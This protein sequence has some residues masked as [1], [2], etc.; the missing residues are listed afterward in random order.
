MASSI[1]AQQQQ[2]AAGKCFYGGCIPPLR[3]GLHAIAIELLKCDDDEAAKQRCC[4]K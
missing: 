4:T 2:E 3:N 1:E